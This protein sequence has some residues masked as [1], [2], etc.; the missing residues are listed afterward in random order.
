MLVETTA[1]APVTGSVT[2][3]NYGNRYTGRAR[4]GGTVNLVD[5]LHDGDDLSLD[6]LTSG[7]GMNYGSLSYQSLL[8]GQG[9]RIGGSYSVL[10]YRLG[11][12]LESL[13]GYGTAQV[14]SLWIQQPLVRT[15][16]ANLYG[17][18]QYD[19]KQLGDYIGAASIRTDR[20]LDNWTASVAGDLRDALLSGGVN[21]WSIGWTLGRVEFDDADAQQTDLAT[22]NSQGGFSKWT[23]NFSRLQGLSAANALNLTISGQWANNNLDPAEKMTAGGPYT[24]RAYDLGVVSGDTGIL[25]SAEFRHGLGQVWNG[26]LQ[27]VTF[28]DSERVTVNR[29]S[30]AAGP[31]SATLSGAG[32]GLNWGTISGWHGKVYVAT[33][34]G[35]TPEL[36]GTG[37]STQAW[38]EIGN[39]FE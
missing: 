14:E 17:Q 2:L 16:D 38:V 29:S 19:H 27:V 21:T 33:P 9:T 25:G 32:V 11:N 30:R 31:N 22:V 15:R 8:N 18:I 7:S 35:S 10:H 20:H 37:K 12:S 5:P 26:Q 36:V 4:L 3:D 28:I 1:T 13:D 6:G 39:R 24:V 34:L 23:A